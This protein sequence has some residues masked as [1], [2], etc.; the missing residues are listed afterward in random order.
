MAER[1]E[2]AVGEPTVTAAMEVTAAKVL[3]QERHQRSK[4]IYSSNGGDGS[5]GSKGCDSSNG[6]NGGEGSDDREGRD[7]CHYEK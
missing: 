3:M 4:G 5:D 6:S 7:V 2:M 1:A